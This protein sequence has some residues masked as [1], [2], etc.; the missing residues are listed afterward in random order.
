MTDTEAQAKRTLES[1]TNMVAAL[2]DDDLQD[3]ASDA[4]YEHPLSVEVRSGWHIPYEPLHPEEYQIMLCT[5]GTGIRLIG[6][7]DSFDAPDTARLEYCDWGIPWTEYPI[8]SD[9][10]ATLLT[11]A[12]MFTYTE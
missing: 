6:L 5:G 12:S 11:Y 1:I 2:Q 9:N 10:E 7:L 3:Q 8:D 4:I